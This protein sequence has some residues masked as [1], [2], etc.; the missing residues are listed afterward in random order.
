[1]KKII[2]SIIYCTT[3]FN[4]SLRA[5]SSMADELKEASTN[6]LSSRFRVGYFGGLGYQG[7]IGG[8]GD[9]RISGLLIE[10]GVYG[11][12]NP[13]QNFLDF[14]V[15][16]SGKYNTGMSSSSNDSDT[17]K[18]KYYAGLKQ[19]TLYGGTV[20]RFGDTKKAIA[21][22]LSKALYI[23]EVQSDELKADGYKK[24]NLENAIGAYVEYQ[25]GNSKIFFTR[26]EIEKIDIVGE[27]ETNKDTVGSILFGIKF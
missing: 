19:V 2:L 24:H 26:I 4:T 22:G 13:I 11:L 14:E 15:G 25:N 20:F 5:E 3:L 23:S 16:L 10:G 8:N 7:R 27:T 18:T 12:F 9:T 1:M 6:S 21:F 17:D